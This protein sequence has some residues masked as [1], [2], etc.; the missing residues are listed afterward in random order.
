MER[1]RKEIKIGMMLNYLSMVIEGIVIFLLNPFITRSLGQ[2]TYGVYTLMT[3][4][5]GYLSVFEFGLGTTIIRYISKYNAE[6]DDKSRESFLS[7]CFIIYFFI[8]LLM[9]VVAIILYKNIENFFA[10]S[11]TVEQIILAKKMFIIIAISMTMTT[12]CSVFSAIISGYEEFI[13][14]RGL[15]LCTAILNV[16]LTVI[17]LATNATAIK[18]T[19]ITLIITIITIISNVLFVSFK[20]KVKVKF[21]GWDKKFFEEIFKFSIFIFLQTII[22]QIY[23]RLDQLIIGVK[24]TN[25]AISLAIYAVAMKINDLVLAFTTVI[26]RYQLPTIT[27]LVLVEKDEEKLMTYLGKTSKFVAILY[28]VIIIGFIF[29]GMRFIEIYAG[30]G[31]ELAY[32]IVLIVIISSA[33]NRIHGCGSDVLKAKNLH[34]I[35]T[36]TIFVSA[37]LNIIFTLIL[38]PKIGIIGAAIGTAI[39][40]VI[41]NTISYYW[42]LQVKAEINIKKLLYLTFKGFVPV[43][44]ISVITGIALNYFMNNDFT[45][46]L[47][48]CVIFT[49]VYIITIYKFVLDKEDKDKIL[50][51]IFKRC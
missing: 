28:M 21:H 34:G 46:Y 24:I 42:C 32:P 48:K 36:T 40:V 6:K 3:S 37:I 35:Y 13:F 22:N 44:F 33:L 15:I 41:G 39:S 1:Q 26:N 12:V 27:R 8:A 5:T 49:I 20:L 7:M 18:L 11:L 14:S 47:V 23:W 19:Y 25:A 30:E 10:N 50:K 4:F 45:N 29:F 38:I 2:E 31:Y 16:I 17:V 51:K 43:I 9:G